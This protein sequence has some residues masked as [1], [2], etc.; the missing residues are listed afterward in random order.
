MIEDPPECFKCEQKAGD[1]GLAHG[2]VKIYSREEDEVTVVGGKRDVTYKT[3]QRWV[4]IEC[5]LTT[6]ARASFE[7]ALDYAEVETQ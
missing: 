3:K 1:G 6:V 5:L 2:L 4:C 7:E